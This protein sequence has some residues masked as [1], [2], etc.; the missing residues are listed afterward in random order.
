MCVMEEVREW[1]KHNFEVN[2]IVSENTVASSPGQFF[3]N[4]TEGEKYGLVLI[5]YGRVCCD[6]KFNSKICRKT[7]VKFNENTDK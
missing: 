1:E 4:I 6:C 7:I 3:A 5:V 2:H